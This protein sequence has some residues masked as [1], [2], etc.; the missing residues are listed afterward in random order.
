MGYENSGRRP[1]PTA[2]KILRGNP[3]KRRLNPAEA[4]PPAA[5]AAFDV[6]PPEL[7]GDPLAQAEWR[8]VAP[9]LRGCRLITEAERTSLIVLC[10][11]WSR[12]VDSQDKIRTLGLLVK[13]PAGVPLRNPYLRIQQDAFGIVNKLSE[14][15]GLTP[16]G[17][18]KIAAIPGDDAPENKWDGLLAS[19]TDARKL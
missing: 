15:L 11:Q 7:E 13:T 1:Q 5:T 4:H 9:M 8:R 6:P 2:L 17:R 3:G 18:A 19:V 16:S 10:Q 14:Q 12:Y